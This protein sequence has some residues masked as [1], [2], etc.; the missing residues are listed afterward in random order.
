MEFKDVSSEIA[1]VAGRYHYHKPPEFLVYLQEMLSRILRFI[2]D[3][4]EQ[5]HLF[6]SDFSDTRMVGNLMQ[7]LLY[8]AGT[9]CALIIIYLVFMRMT[10]LTQMSRLA[11]AGATNSQMLLTSQGW[12]A[13]AKSLAEKEHY[14]SACRAAYLSFLRLLDE[15]EIAPFSPTR[16]NYEYWYQLNKSREIQVAFGNL[17]DIVE[18]VWFGNK[19]AVR[20][21]FERCLELIESARPAIAQ[22]SETKQTQSKK[23]EAVS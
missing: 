10:K 13:E 7:V 16:T 3:L 4:L 5:L 19:Q 14:K 8:A 21:D 15:Q 1:D 23:P 17:A 12:L 18:L 22:L 2:K 6:N 20:A 11:R 9:L